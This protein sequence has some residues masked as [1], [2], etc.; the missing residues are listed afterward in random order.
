MKYHLYL[1]A[2]LILFISCKKNVST[3]KEENFGK[4]L[5][6]Y[7]Q[8]ECFDSTGRYYLLSLSDYQQSQYR[9]E[10]PINTALSNN[11]IALTVGDYINKGRNPVFPTAT[12]KD[13]LASPRGNIKIYEKDLVHTTYKVSIQVKGLEKIGTLAIWQDSCSIS[14]E[15]ND[16]TVSNKT[17]YLIPRQLLLLYVSYSGSSLTPAV[18]QFVTELESVG[19]YKK[20]VPPY[21]YRYLTVGADGTIPWQTWEPDNYAR[22][23]IFYLKDWL[24]AKE[25]A[26]KHA[27]L[28]GKKIAIHLYSTEGN[29]AHFN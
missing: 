2:P 15:N 14:F 12:G 8:H 16:I 4:K 19:F 13:S 25:I 28:N 22:G 6:I 9:Y 10:I 5:S 24:T 11:T 3:S 21:P 29:E 18:N 26:S 27:A 7:W 1:I 17:I 23:Y 20:Q